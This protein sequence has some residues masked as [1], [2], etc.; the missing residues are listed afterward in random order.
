MLLK[1]AKQDD[2]TVPLSESG[3]HYN[4]RDD[5]YKRYKGETYSWIERAEKGDD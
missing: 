3:N 2:R 4:N 1:K 5:F